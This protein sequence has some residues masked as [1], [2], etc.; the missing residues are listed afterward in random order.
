MKFLEV[1]KKKIKDWKVKRNWEKEVAYEWRNDKSSYNVKDNFSK[2][3]DEFVQT[4]IKEDLIVCLDNS[5]TVGIKNTNIK[6][7]AGNYPYSY[8]SIF[9]PF[10]YKS[11][12]FRQLPSKSTIVLLKKHIDIL[13][14]PPFKNILEGARGAVDNTNIE[15][16]PKE[17]RK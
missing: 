4:C 2:E 16:N 10:D 12:K 6:L 8:G 7:W 11:Y 13:S 1:L 14:K 3:L 5:Y 15:Y 9:T 17:F